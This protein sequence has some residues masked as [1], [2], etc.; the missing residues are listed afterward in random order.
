MFEDDPFMW[1]LAK[2]LNSDQTLGY[3]GE[4]KTLIQICYHIQI[5]K[6]I[7]IILGYD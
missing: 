3:F 7:I 2:T 4:Y 1:N 5:K 6:L